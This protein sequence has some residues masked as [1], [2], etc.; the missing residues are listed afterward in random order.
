MHSQI[1]RPISNIT[2][3]DPAIEAAFPDRF[4][5]DSSGQLV[6]VD[7]RPVNFDSARSDTLRIGFDFSKPLKSRRPSQSVMDQIRAQF[8][9]AARPSRRTRCA[10]L[11]RVGSAP[12]PPP[13]EGGPP[14]SG[15]PESWRRLRWAAVVAVA[16]AVAAD[17]S[18]AA[19][20]AGC[21]FR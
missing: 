14:P 3:T 1:D 19:A 2:V 5:R 7:L 8:G 9:G 4:V 12:P 6:S 20:A 18:A 10:R 13:P 15:P 16:A 17:S 21:N 11:R